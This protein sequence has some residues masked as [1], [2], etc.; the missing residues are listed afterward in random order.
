MVRGKKNYLPPSYLIM[1]YGFLFKLDETS[2]FRHAGERRVKIQEESQ[3]EE[4]EAQEEGETL[5]R[6]GSESS[7]DE[8]D[9]QKSDSKLSENKEGGHQEKSKQEEKSDLGEWEER[10][11][12]HS[13]GE[14]S[15]EEE[16]EDG[17]GELQHENQ[18]EGGQQEGTTTNEDLL[19]DVDF[20]ETTDMLSL[21]H[22]NREMKKKKK[23]PGTG[24]VCEAVSSS[25]GLE[26]EGVKDK[27]KPPASTVS[28]QPLP[29]TRAQKSKQKKMRKYK[30]QDDEERELRMKLLGS[31]PQPRE[32]KSKKGKKGN[33]KYEAT[34][35]I[36][37]GKGRGGGQLQKGR[38]EMCHPLVNS[39]MPVAPPGDVATLTEVEQEDK[40]GEDPEQEAQGVQDGEDLLAS[41]T[42]QPHVDDLLMF[43]IPVC[44]PYTALS[45]YKYKVKLTPGTQKKGKGNTHY[46]CL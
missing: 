34:K 26:S 32:D 37:K 30:D 16:E 5:G 46:F 9:D 22:I 10:L 33:P 35:G 1:G 23:E 41:L 19:E 12:E 43:S 38:Q 7:S 29:L 18:V 3:K 44:A 25:P 2:V 20:N 27:E 13:E 17:G 21:S 6:S 28:Q 11:S 4:A 31:V 8:E 42:G 39:G 36:Q 45:N 40:V 15:T 14:E 24:S